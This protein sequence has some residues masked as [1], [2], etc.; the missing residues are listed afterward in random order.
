MN[1]CEVLPDLKPSTSKLN[2]NTRNNVNNGT[3]I[4]K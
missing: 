4:N 1:A 2:V 3:I